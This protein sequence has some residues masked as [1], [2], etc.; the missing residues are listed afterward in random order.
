[1]NGFLCVT[2]ENPVKATSASGQYGE[3]LLARMKRLCPERL[4]FVTSAVPSPKILLY[5]REL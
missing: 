4:C 1:M 5:P 2:G 3:N